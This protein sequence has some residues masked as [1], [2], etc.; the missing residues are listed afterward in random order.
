MAKDH[1]KWEE[2]HPQ[3]NRSH[4]IRFQDQDTPTANS[5]A[6]DDESIASDA[7]SEL[8]DDTEAIAGNFAGVS[9]RWI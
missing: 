3:S 8:E 4:T 6:V 9:A 1:A 7:S 5:A 2:N